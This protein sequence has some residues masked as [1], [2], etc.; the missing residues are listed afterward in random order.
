[1]FTINL[2]KNFTVKRFGKFT[3]RCNNYVINDKSILNKYCIQVNR[4]N[5]VNVTLYLVYF[6]YLLLFLH[7]IRGYRIFVQRIASN[8]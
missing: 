7:F 5:F 4:S 2:I 1:M 8:L 3:Q 6:R